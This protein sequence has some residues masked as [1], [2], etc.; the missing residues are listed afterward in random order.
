MKFQHLII[1][2]S[3]VFWQKE[4]LSEEWNRKR[5]DMF[6]RFLRP[7]L[8]KQTNK[9]FK[10]ISL[11]GRFYN[12]GE[13]PNEYKEFVEV[14]PIDATEDK[15]KRRNW[16]I[17]F[18]SQIREIAKKHSTAEFTLISRIDSDDYVEPDYVEKLQKAVKFNECPYYY[19]VDK[20]FC[21]RIKTGKIT[22]KTEHKKPRNT[23]AFVSVLEKP[24]VCYPYSFPHQD[25]GKKMNG[26]ILS[27]LNVH[28][29]LHDLNTS[30]IMKHKKSHSL[31][32]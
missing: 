32:I 3:N 23:S 11:W 14:E 27:G 2:R 22:E 5:L 17:S 31:K 24:I 7:S 18:C 15:E 8:A 13:I 20:I 1:T 26:R 29:T 9:D 6:N 30:A 12:G 16:S 28:L 21:V 4:A 10:F 25:I 19:D